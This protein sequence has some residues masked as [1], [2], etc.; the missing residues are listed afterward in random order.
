MIPFCVDQG[1][2]IVCWSPLARGFLAGNRTREKG[3]ETDRSHSDTWAH[4]AY[5]LD[6]D[7]E[8]VDAVKEIAK[9]HGVTPAQIALAWVLHKPFVCAPIVGA[10]KPKHL[11]EAAGALEVKLSPEEMARLEAHYQPHPVAM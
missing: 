7:F 9:Q 8:V 4:G 2:A 11:E 1:T 5:Y 10:T 6:S 3:G